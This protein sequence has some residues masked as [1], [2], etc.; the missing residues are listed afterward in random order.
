MA[1]PGISLPRIK[2]SINSFLMHCVLS[3]TLMDMRCCKP[4][5]ESLQKETFPPQRDKFHLADNGKR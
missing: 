4:L 5:K 1:L 3:E 2:D